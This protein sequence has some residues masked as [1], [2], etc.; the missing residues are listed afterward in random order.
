MKKHIKKTAKKVLRPG[1]RRFVVTRQIV[2]SVGLVKRLPRDP[3]YAEWIER[4]EPK[5]WSSPKELSYQPK[6]SIVVPVF[7]PPGKYFLA[8][9]H[10][11]TSQTYQHWQLVLV[12]ASTDKK[13]RQ[14]VAG[15]V[16]IDQ[17]IKVVT[18]KQ[19]KGIAGNTNAG[20]Q[21]AD[22]DYVALLDHDDILAP[23]ALF[24]VASVLQIED[25]PTLVYS[26]EDKLSA[27]GEERFDPHFKPDWSPE[28]MSQLNYINHFTVIKK[29]L[30]DS[31]DGY[32]SGYDGA[33][34][35]DLYLR[36]IDLKPIVKH[37]PRILY[38]WRAA[39]T[40]TARDFSTKKGVLE[41]GVRAVTDHL[42]RNNRV[43][44][45]SPLDG[46]PGF[47]ETVYLPKES[48]ILAVILNS[49]S[50]KDQYDKFA[51]QI[52]GLLSECGLAAELILQKPAETA[53]ESSKN[54]KITYLDSKSDQ[55]LSNAAAST[56]AKTCI[57]FNAA[58]LPQKAKF[59]KDLAAVTMQVKEIGLVSPHILTTDGETIFDCGY[60][61]VDNSLVPIFQGEA[62]GD[63][64]YFGNT[65]WVRNLD[66][67]SGRCFGMRTQLLE[68][69]FKKN[70]AYDPTALS[71]FI[72]ALEKRI[73][74][75]QFTP[76]NYHG[77]FEYS[78][79][80]THYLNPQLLRSGAKLAV[81]KTINVPKEV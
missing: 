18:M 7:N 2:Q 46:Q 47:Y 60:V 19:N 22:G 23:Q 28:L 30:I 27:N 33:Q 73:V 42:E 13:S 58:A 41:A 6:I 70:G 11:V 72:A 77:D 34:D 38:H 37:V 36:L 76:F 63:H 78:E 17:R 25:K 45:V 59:M 53:L 16:S 61:K 55:F 71:A 5:C 75:W 14:Q 15:S 12:N 9:V 64:T 26:D 57:V 44:V 66:A 65:D 43:G 10:S 1:T 51:K 50:Q 79:S 29:S 32:R 48:E 31:L 80:Q 8:M 49:C 81:P 56:N 20:I 4:T 35:F 39:E 52:A 62:W 24:E 21:A 54:V 74:S 68:E 69:Y 67:V 3:Q 40:S